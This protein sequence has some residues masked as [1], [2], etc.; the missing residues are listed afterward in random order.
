MDKNKLG[1][2][3]FMHLVVKAF[4]GHYFCDDVKQFVYF[5]FIRFKTAWMQQ[6]E[7]EF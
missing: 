3:L 6:L 2:C 4:D 7:G 1:S 5:Y